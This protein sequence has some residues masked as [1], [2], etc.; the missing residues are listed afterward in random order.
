VKRAAFALALLVLGAC[1]PAKAPE[2][3]MDAAHYLDAIVDTTA[4]PRQDFDA[5]ATGKWRKEHPIPPT[6][7]SFGIGH[8]VQEET[9]QRLVGINQDAGAS[10]APPGSN[11]QKIGDFWAAAMDSV[12]AAK[13]GFAP[14]QEEFDGI[15]AMATA[16]DLLR[17]IAHLKHIG[18]DCAPAMPI[19]QDEK[20]S[21]R[22]TLHLY[23]G[24][25]GLPN[26]DYYLDTDAKSASIRGEY[27]RHVAKMFALLGDDTT[28]ARSRAQTVMA[29]ETEL[30]KASR[31][32]EA[33]RDP[34][35]N[36][37]RMTLVGASRLAPSMKWEQ[38]LDQ[39]AIPNVDTVIVGQPEYFRQLERTL[40]PRSPT[41]RATCA[42][43]WPT[44]TPPRPGVNSRRRTSGSTAPCSTARPR[45]ARAGSACSTRRRPTWATRSGSSTSRSTARPRP[46]RATR[47][48]STT[49][50]RRSARASTASTG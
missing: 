32:L 30:A 28:T 18:V 50:S 10:H 16:D 25:L 24:G 44:T 22:N 8:V 36:Y 3:S 46:R 15:D 49:S 38:F 31:K 29:M 23:Q 34:E 13:Q 33:L 9:Y 1:A 41:G 2:K 27:V 20:N 21:A 5:F 11:A 12:G 19:L 35:A 47:S 37:H 43:T 26:R 42:G 17:T 40:H 48:W 7:R 4:D 45:T 39:A 6:E 14:L